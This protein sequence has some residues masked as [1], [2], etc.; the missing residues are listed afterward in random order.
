MDYF[1]HLIANKASA[2]ETVKIRKVYV[3]EDPNQED[4][5]PCPNC[6]ARKQ[7]SSVR[8]MYVNLQEAIY[9]CESPD[10]MYP[11]QNFKFKNYTDNTVYFYIS[12]EVPSATS[13]NEFESSFT[14]LCSPTK[15][16]IEPLKTI[17][18]HSST[19]DFSMHFFS[20]D[21][22]IN[23]SIK[24]LENTPG[25]NTSI[26]IFDSPTL[27]YKNLVQDFDTGFIDD[28]LQDLGQTSSPEKQK[29]V[30]VSPV[31]V[32][33][34]ESSSVASRQLKRCLQIF[35]NTATTSEMTFKV[36]PLPGAEVQTPPKIRIKK[37][38]PLRRHKHIRRANSSSNS[39]SL[40]KSSKRRKVKPLDF[41]ETIINKHPREDEQKPKQSNNQRVENMLNF[42]ERSMKH[43]QSQPIESNL[44]SLPPLPPK[45]STDHIPDTHRICKKKQKRISLSAAVLDDRQFEYS[46]SESEQEDAPERIP[47]PTAAKPT[48]SG[49]VSPETSLSTSQL[50]SDS[51][52]SLPSFEDLLMHIHPGQPKPQTSFQ[53]VGF[54]SAG[55]SPTRVP[56]WA[57]TPPRRI[58]SMESLCSL[59]E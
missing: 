4:I 51:D 50:S 18:D 20:P 1:A 56:Q 55:S 49:G 43:R 33:K 34:N 39:L 48:F 25:N 16:K 8:Y 58:H 13:P 12:A 37:N 21:R 59:L 57:K 47:I 2:T 30:L 52:R 41:I 10:C 5:K 28:L 7:K 11:Y 19:I 22:G 6:M 23:N 14:S 31:R 26:N 24:A 45:H 53:N 9:K 35:Q 54:R 17:D 38:S 40:E 15:F 46:A 42:I 36:P 29:P 32:V 44:Q 3:N 27:S